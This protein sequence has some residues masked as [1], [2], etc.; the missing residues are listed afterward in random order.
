[1]KVLVTGA[2][3]FIGAHVVRE[4]L[5][6]GHHAYAM[7]RP[8]GPTTRLQD[9]HGCID[10]I[11]ADLGDV[12]AI[13]ALLESVRPDAIVHLAWY[14]EPGRYQH[15]VAEN[16][17][18]LEASATLMVAAAESHCPRLVLAGTC[19]ENADTPVRT[20]YDAAKSAAHALSLGLTPTGMSVACGHVFYVYGPWE[21]ERRVIPTVIRALL[22][23]E[24]IATTDGLQLRDYLHVTDVAS[25]FAVLAESSL[26]GGVDICSGSLISLKEVLEVIDEEVSRPA[27]LHIGGLGSTDDRGYESA[28]D[29]LPLMGLGWLPR[30]VLRSGIRETVAWWNGRQEAAT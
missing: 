19:L 30:H 1:M 27:L 22:S 15:A 28:G 8:G 29:P 4:L 11:E 23:N 26:T 3:G 6:R 12:S 17:A 7:L 25:A 14:A 9:V 18:S 20:I 5:A 2:G 13:S 21:D 16:V 10:V 24:P